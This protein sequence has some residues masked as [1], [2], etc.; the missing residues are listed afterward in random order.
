LQEC[1]WRWEQILQGFCF[2]FLRAPSRAMG[3][4]Q[5]DRAAKKKSAKVED[6]EPAEVS[7]SSGEMVAM[8]KELVMS[9]VLVQLAPKVPNLVKDAAA[10]A[11]EPASKDENTPPENREGAENTEGDDI[12]KDDAPAAK[13]PEAEGPGAIFDGLV[14]RLQFHNAL[15][16]GLPATGEESK[17]AW[18]RLK[19]LEVDGGPRSRKKGSPAMD[20]LMANGKANMPQYLHVLLALMMLRAFLF[21]S[22]FACLPWLFLYQVLSLMCPLEWPQFPQV[23]KVEVRYRVAVSVAIH[24]LMWLFFLFEAVYKT[25]I[26]EKM[27]L[28]GL[29]AAHAYV[30][31]PAD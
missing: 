22:W 19:G 5:A 9:S 12:K 27:L 25:Y 7:A 31:R 2:P 6:D 26:V 8:A 29:F 23:P 18:L 20:R 17:A 24:A 4:K 30:V 13:A 11:P 28:V 3:G 1:A 21:R 15:G 10:A 14:A 16:L